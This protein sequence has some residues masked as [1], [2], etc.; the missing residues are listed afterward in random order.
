M[1]ALHDEAEVR[2]R[3][4]PVILGADILGYSFVRGFHETYGLRSIVLSSSDIKMTSSSRFCDYRIIE[5]IDDEDELVAELAR[6]GAEIESSGKCGLV[7][8]SGDWYARILSSHKAELERWYYVPYIDFELLDEITQKERFYDLCEE[9]GIPYPRTWKF[10]CAD[11]DARIDAEQ[12]TY[13]LIAKPSNSARYHYAKFP[14]KKKIFE[15]E[16]AAELTRIFEALKGSCYDRE[17]IVQEFIPGADDGLRTITIYM[18]ADGTPA[19]TCSGRVVLQDHHPAAIGNPVCIMSDRVDEAIEDAIRLLKHVGYRGF[20]NFDVKLDPRDGKF[21]FFEV[22]TRP[23]RNTYYVNL[24]G[25]NFVRL[26]VN[27]YVLGRT[28]ERFDALKPF[29]FACV[30]PY[31]VKRTVEDP[32]LREQVLGMYRDGLAVFPLFYKPDTLTQRFWSAM[33]YYHQISKFKRYVWDT[34]GKQASVD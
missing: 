31:V 3:L 6:I 11:P 10:D 18:N 23:G 12:F 22:N 2:E 9:L 26:I 1:R 19:M 13:P 33:A 29:L 4:V 7:V 24:A 28:Q 17:L 8:G 30:P 25:A 15:V 20:A 21:K 32:A 16:D 5:G 27:D 34:G 14:G